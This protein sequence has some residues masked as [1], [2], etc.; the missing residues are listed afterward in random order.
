MYLLY[1]SCQLIAAND[2]TCLSITKI[3]I[4]Q[5]DIKISNSHTHN[6]LYLLYTDLKIVTCSNLYTFIDSRGGTQAFIVKNK[7]RLKF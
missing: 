3:F 1:R 7:T 4:Q 5:V 6:I 2:Y